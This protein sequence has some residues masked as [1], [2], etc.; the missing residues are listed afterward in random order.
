MHREGAMV[1]LWS[2]SVTTAATLPLVSVQTMEIGAPIDTSPTAN[3]PKAP[4]VTDSSPSPLMVNAPS[5]TIP[6]PI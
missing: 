1:I 2:L 6:E 3:T 4:A 5:L